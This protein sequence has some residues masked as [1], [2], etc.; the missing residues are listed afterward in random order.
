MHIAMGHVHTHIREWKAAVHILVAVVR[1]PRKRDVLS[2]TNIGASYT[3]I[4]RAM[5]YVICSGM[6][7]EAHVCLK[8]YVDNS[9]KNSERKLRG[10]VD[11]V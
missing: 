6:A 11:S 10:A 3:S 5:V 9:I 4:A 7:S 8:K 1:S 2:Q